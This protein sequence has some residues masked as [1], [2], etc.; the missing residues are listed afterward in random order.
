KKGDEVTVGQTL[1]L[2]EPAKNGAEVKPDG[3]ASAERKETP[4]EPEAK[5]AEKQPVAAPKR[6]VAEAETATE[7]AERERPA[8]KPAAPA[9]AKRPSGDGHAAARAGEKQVPA[10]PAT[11]RLARELGVNLRLV[12][13]S[14][15]GGRIIEEDVKEY[16]R[17]IA[18]GAMGPA[19]AA[20]A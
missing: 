8:P 14:A 12:H 19:I 13:G 3:K 2:L 1:C 20:P 17:Q 10:G 16:V 15:P 11:R 7:V 18:S 6:K 5:P 9:V 4:T